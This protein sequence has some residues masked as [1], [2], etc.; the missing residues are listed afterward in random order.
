MQTREKE[1]TTSKTSTKRRVFSGVQPTGSVHL[2]NYLGAFRGWARRQAEKENFFCI[3]DLH[4]ITVYQEPDELRA[5]TR[6]LAAILF[7]VGLDPDQCTVFVQSHVRAHAEGAWL[8]NCVT[9]LGWLE[10]MTQYK[11][12]S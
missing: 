2:G 3:V 4:A 5:Q 9:P 10:R 11:D 8:L 12:K 7:A 6:E 1:T